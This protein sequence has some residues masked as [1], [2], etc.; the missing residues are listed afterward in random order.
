MI[1]VEDLHW[2]AG[3]L[4]GEG[5]IR[6]QRPA[7]NHLGH[8]EVDIVN[9]D[10]SIV[11]LFHKTWGGSVTPYISRGRRKAYWRWRCVSKVA[12]EFL[13]AMWVVLRTDRVRERCNLA[14]EFQ[15]QKEQTN[16]ASEEYRAR[17]WAFFERM[18]ELNRR[19]SLACPQR[20]QFARR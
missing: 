1:S 10:E 2:Q 4:E 17:Q 6:I 20:Q 8:I 7:W 16:A 18:R 15:Q 11:R 5:C 9:T 3:I 12:E 14:L 19:G 13:L